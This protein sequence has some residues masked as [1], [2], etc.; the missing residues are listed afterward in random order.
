VFSSPLAIIYSGGKVLW[1]PPAKLVSTCIVDL[2]Y[3]PNDVQNCTMKF[4]SWVHSADDIDVFQKDDKVE[5]CSSF[6]DN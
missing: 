3:W 5:V 4:G 6:V 2:K 1:I